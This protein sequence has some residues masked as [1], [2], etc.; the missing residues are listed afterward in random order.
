MATNVYDPLY[1]AVDATT[2]YWSSPVAETISSIPIAGGA[3]TTLA[4]HQGNP[5]E[6]AVNHS[7]VVWLNVGNDGGPGAVVS[8]PK[9]GGTLVDL[10]SGAFPSGLAL[11]DTE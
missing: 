2:L 9:A 1:V 8:L 6:I 3:V 5:H 10:T 11:D 4:T 7:S